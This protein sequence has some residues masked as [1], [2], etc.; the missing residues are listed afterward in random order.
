MGLG[1]FS[2]RRGLGVAAPATVKPKGT[3]MLPARTPRPRINSALCAGA[4]LFA[5][6]AGACASDKVEARFRGRASPYGLD[7]QVALD[8]SAMVQGMQRAHIGRLSGL[9]C[10]QAIAPGCA[11]RSPREN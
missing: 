9:A 10:E 7:Q 3:I 8:V 1:S 4:L 11:R 6:L 2:A 5:L